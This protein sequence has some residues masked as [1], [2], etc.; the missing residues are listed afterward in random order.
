M[1]VY[2]KFKQLRT[3]SINGLIFKKSAE[4]HGYPGRFL[5]RGHLKLVEIIYIAGVRMTFG[6][7]RVFLGYI[8]VCRALHVRT[9]PHRSG[10]WIFEQILP[11]SRQSFTGRLLRKASHEI[12]TQPLAVGKI[13]LK[14]HDDSCLD[15]L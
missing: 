13:C 10:G 1:P 12:L 3:I 4:M 6:L 8:T 11:K 2:L 7:I 15:R 14:T 9:C 5:R